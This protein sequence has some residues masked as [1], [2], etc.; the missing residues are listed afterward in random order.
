MKYSALRKQTVKPKVYIETTII[1]YL[2]AQPSRDIVVAGHQQITHDWWINCHERF[3]I[4]TSQLVIREAGVGDP[5]LARTRLEILERIISLEASDDA[6]KLA[7]DLINSGAMPKKAAEDALHIA[8]AV[9]NGVEYLVTWNCKHLANAT[10]RSQ[11]EKI[12]RIAGYEPTI[13]CTPE[14]LLE[15]E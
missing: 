3:D 6:L 11:I 5:I 10:M 8:I 9:T 4:V 14:E 1:S 13:I 7:G 15:V 2:T 12:C